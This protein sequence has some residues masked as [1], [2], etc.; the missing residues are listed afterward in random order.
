[1]NLLEMKS[2]LLRQRGLVSAAFVAA[3]AGLWPGVPVVVVLSNARAMPNLG[4]C[5]AAAATLAM[6]GRFLVISR[7]S[8]ASPEPVA[9]ALARFGGVNL[10]VLAFFSALSF[11]RTDPT[12][13]AWCFGCVIASD[14]WAIIAS[15]PAGRTTRGFAVVPTQTSPAVTDHRGQPQRDQQPDHEQDQHRLNDHSVPGRRAALHDAV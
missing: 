6:V 14:A 1:M 9:H 15:R 11:L 7:P 4:L 8:T 10:L 2:D 5:C 3:S 13:A 12:A